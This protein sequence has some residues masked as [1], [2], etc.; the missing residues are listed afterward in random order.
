MCIFLSPSMSLIF[1]VAMMA[2]GVG[3]FTIMIKVMPKFRKVFERYDDLNASVQ[4]N[5]SAIRVVKAFVREDFEDQKF[6]HAAG[7]CM[8][9]SLPRSLCLRGTTPS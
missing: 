7:S 5:V 4:E 6:T 2:L 9:S 8:T 1:V 3:L